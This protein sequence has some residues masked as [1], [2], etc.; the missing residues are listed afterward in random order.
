MEIDWLPPSRTHL[1]DVI[2]SAGSWQIGGI[3][4]VI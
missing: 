1:S 3:T 2:N 4:I